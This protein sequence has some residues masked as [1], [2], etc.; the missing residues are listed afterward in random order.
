MSR[1]EDARVAE[2]VMGWTNVRFIDNGR[3]LYGSSP[4][5]AADR[6][7]DFT[8]DASADYTVLEYVREN[9][10]DE[11]KEAFDY[12]LSILQWERREGR[13]WH[14]TMCSSVHGSVYDFV[15]PLDYIKGDNSRAALAVVAQT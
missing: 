14:E 5:D 4:F 9:W 7:P 1:E 2:L 15:G 13:T 6:V 10:T 8:T 3:E 11:Q 12:R